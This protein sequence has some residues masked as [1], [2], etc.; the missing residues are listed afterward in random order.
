ME[1][2]NLLELDSCPTDYPPRLMTKVILHKV[3]RS[4]LVLLW[5]EFLSHEIGGRQVAMWLYCQRAINLA[6]L[7]TK[8][9]VDKMPILFFVV[10]MKNSFF[11]T[12][13]ERDCKQSTCWCRKQWTLHTPVRTCLALFRALSLPS[14][15]RLVTL[16]DREVC[17]GTC[18]ENLLSVA[19]MLWV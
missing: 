6:R 3:Q 7:Q 17:Q 14:S 5:A 12:E 15:C 18:Q 13:K 16:E 4:F 2:K 19:F 11:V 10:W 1:G 9:I 8:L